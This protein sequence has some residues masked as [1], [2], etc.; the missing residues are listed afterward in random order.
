MY[1]KDYLGKKQVASATP[2]AAMETA[3][4]NFTIK[5]EGRFLQ[6][7]FML[8]LTLAI[9]MGS[10]PGLAQTVT[11]TLG[12]I[13]QDNDGLIEIC[14]LDGL[15]AIRYQLDGSGY[16]PSSSTLKITAGC[17]AIGCKGYELTRDLD[18]NDN[19][20]Y[21]STAN[22]ITWTTGKGW[23]PIGTEASPF[24]AIFNANKHRI[25]N[26]MIDRPSARNVALF[27]GIGS[28]A[29]IGGIGLINV[30]VRGSWGI[31]SLAGASRGVISSSYATGTIRG[32][33]SAGGLVG[34]NHGRITNSYTNVS[35]SGDSFIGG[36]VGCNYRS[37]TVT[38]SYTVPRINSSK[39]SRG[40]ILGNESGSVANS[41]WDMDV[42]DISNGAFGLGQTSTQLQSPTVATGI[43]SSWNA[44]VWDFGTPEQYPALKYSDGTV[45][46]DQP[47]E[48][49]EIPQIASPTSCGTTDIDQDDDGLIEICNLD[50]LRAIRYQLDG[51]GY[52]ASV[53]AAKITE[54]CPT[55]GCKGY[56]LS[57]DL[58][59]N[60]DDSYSSTANKITWTT[61]AG[62]EPI[63]YLSL[64]QH[65]PF[66]AT[67]DGN[68]HIISN[69]MIN[70]SGP[71]ALGLFSYV[72]RQS[73]IANVGLLNVNVILGNTAGGNN[74][75]GGLAGYN[76]R[77]SITN[78][79]VTGS[80]SGTG[81]Q[82]DVGGLI[83]FLEVG[84][85][86]NS[87]V[88][89]TISGGGFHTDV[90]GLVGQNLYGGRITNSYAAGSVSGTGYRT[91]VG[92]LVGWNLSRGTITN[93]YAA[94]AISGPGFIGGLIGS[95]VSGG[96][97]NSYWDKQISG[98]T[99]V[100][101]GIGKTTLELQE[102]TAATGIYSGWSTD[103]W[104]FGTSEQ[105]PALK[106]RDGT[107]M[108]NQGREPSENMLQMPQIEIA[109]VPTGA[110]D[111]GNSITL[112]ASSASSANAIPLLYS[113]SEIPS[114]GGD[115]LIQF[116]TQSSMTIEVPEDYVPASVNTV[117]LTIM[118]LAM[119]DVGSTSTV[120][121]T[122]KRVSITIAKRNNGKIAALG[123]PS[124]NERELTAPP[125]DLSG[126]PDG[127]VSNIGYQWQS[128]EDAQSAWVNVPVGTSVAYTIPENVFGTVQYRV[129]VSYTDGQGYSE[130]VISPAVVYESRYSLIEIMN[131]TS[132]GTTDVD[133]DDDGL[134]EICNLDGLNA[135]RYQL[136]GS[137]YRPSSSTLNITAGCPA[138]GCKGYELSADLD[139]GDDNSYSSTTNKITWTT[140]K[141]WQPIGAE[142]SPFNAIF[143]ANGHSISN[144][145]IDR[146]SARNVGLFGGIGGSAIVEGIALINVNVRGSWGIAS[147]AGVNRGVISSSYATGTIRGG[148]SAGGLVGDNHGQITNSYTNV[149]VSGGSWI[150]GI[151]GCNFSGGVVTNSYTVSRI[152][153]SSGSR[154]GILGNN[155]GSVANSYWDRDVNGIF[156]EGFGIGLTT[157]QLQSPI[158][159][160]STP[161]DTYYD[162]SA[163][164]WD[165]GTAE[166]YPA[167]KYRDGTVIPNQPRERPEL[168][169]SEAEIAR[170]TSCGT[171]DI[172]QDDDGLIEICNLEGLNAIRYQLDGTGYRADQSALMITMGCRLDGGCTGYELTRD[173]D[174]NDDNSYSS[175]ANK[176][177]WATGKGWE[178][179]GEM[180][181]GG[182]FMAKFEGNG[183]TIS[184]LMIN[185][186]E[187][188]YAGLFGYAKEQSEIVNIGLLNINVLGSYGAGGLA[189]VNKG[190]IT[191]SYVSGSVTGTTY[192][193]VGGLVA[194]NYGGTITSS[195]AMGSVSGTGW[196]TDVGGLVGKNYGGSITNSY[197][198][199][200]VLGTGWTTDVGG[201][202]GKN[203]GGS[204]TNSYAMGSVSGNGLFADIGGLIGENHVGSITNS[205]ATG[206]VAGSG[207]SV[208]TGGLVGQNNGTFTNSYWDKT[209]SGRVESAAGEGKTTVELQSPTAPGSTSTK[210]YY[211][212][213]AK[214]W[215]FGT[216]EQY[217]ILKHRDGT[218]M[219]NQP[220]TWSG[221]GVAGVPTDAINE[222]E[223]IT[224][225]AFPLSDEGDISLSYH[226]EQ[227]S[228]KAL[229][230]EPTTQSS[231]TLEV[232]ENY[233]SAS[234]NTA[235]LTIALMVDSDLGTTARQVVI[236]IAKQ[237]NGRIEALGAPS[238]NE[239]ELSA[240][241]IDLSGDPDGGV[242][243]ISYQWQ[244]MQSVQSTQT[245]WMNVPAGTN[246][247]YT[248]A[249]DYRGSIE[250]RV[251]VNYTDGQGYSEVARSDAVVYE[252]EYSMTEIANIISCRA[253]DIDQDDDGLIEIC[254]LE[255]LNAMRYQW[256]GSGYREDE[257][258]AK[259]TAGCGEGGCRGYE[260]VKDL[261]F[262]NS[263]HYRDL[264]NKTAWTT[265]AGW[266]PM[267]LESVFEGND[268]TIANLM[269]D[270]EQAGHVGLFGVASGG[271][272]SINGVGL[273]DVDIKAR[274]SAGG[275]VGAIRNGVSISNSY[276]T[277]DVVAQAKAGGLVGDCS[278]SAISDSHAS[279]TVSIGY[280]SAGGL[281][282]YLLVCDVS[283]SHA[284]SVVKGFDRVGGLVG[285]NNGYSNGIS[286]SYAIADVAGRGYYV[287]GL[288]G[289][290]SGSGSIIGSYAMGEVLGADT[291]GGLVGYNAARYTIRDSYSF[292]AVKGRNHVG[293]LV[294]NHIGGIINSYSV[295]SVIATG[296]RARSGG[297]VGL[298]QNS[299]MDSYW[300]KTTSGKAQSA[301]SGEGKTTAQLQS[302]T[303]TTTEIYSSWDGGIWDFGTSEQYPALKRSDG[304]LLPGQRVGLLSL[305]VF[306]SDEIPY[307][308][309]S[310]VFDYRLL[311]ANEVDTIKLLPTATSGSAVEIS[312]VSD[313]GFSESVSSGSLS[314]EISLATTQTTLITVKVDFAS[315]AS[316]TYRLT[317]SRA[318]QS[319]LAQVVGVN[320]PF[321]Y[322]F[323]RSALNDMQ[324]YEVLNMPEW[325]EYEESESGLM[326]SGTPGSD[327]KEGSLEQMLELQ[328]NNDDGTTETMSIV[329]QIDSPTT[330]TVELME[331]PGGVLQ[332]NDE[333]SDDNGIIEK[334]HIWEH[335]PVGSDEFNELEGVDGMSY[336]LP[337]GEYSVPGTAYR[338][339]TTV[340]DSLGQR[341][342]LTT[343][344]E[345]KPVIKLRIKVFL[346]GFL[347]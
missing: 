141:G 99:T 228:G 106:Y 309:N 78:S 226:W 221:V 264:D 111:E 12:D 117:D 70:R 235:Y 171:T 271:D 216:S 212:W 108:P 122:V 278:Y 236:T 62:W 38:N 280:N 209:T 109:G 263:D 89:G 217:P 24:T 130:E 148:D 203:Y 303:T 113:W 59:F 64:Y 21:S 242:G 250:Y 240:P 79:Y 199:G 188:S 308:F 19:D 317:I 299:I 340:V 145:M 289:I 293:G 298:S 333:L 311:I 331:L 281:A 338:V 13:D 16:R 169:I 243:D 304:T 191:N 237:N 51:T 8:V 208:N 258:S 165:F 11:C 52:K 150:G 25:S 183:Y 135:M 162:W 163:D 325:L 277:G 102:P 114:E 15:D 168:Q 91:D 3:I 267:R 76:Y 262:N 54:G 164:V 178:P 224:L 313:N 312:I 137:G 128:R 103:V 115:L 307:M 187:P 158:A 34:D 139:F 96:I 143:K 192:A 269:I 87:F 282:G 153:S 10:Q 2:S 66:V 222:G 26:L 194:I 318:E 292:A 234:I 160:G 6:A 273:I 146:P 339:R 104:D 324:S 297:L 182:R 134:I 46:P 131:L 288:I 296:F 44:G 200:S 283:D 261:D 345:L 112:T 204:V 4:P 149:S 159:A 85:I 230:L 245:G 290:N 53:S 266:E 227:K 247:R 205:Y 341:S 7:L 206:S 248:I 254:D 120:S 152:N 35:V 32:G 56:E 30:N 94:G 105:Y 81:Y 300:D 80:V 241:P 125:I 155:S 327:H 255:G 97:T 315:Q 123:T 347:Q 71:Y 181:G 336:T 18:F 342:E 322:V 49:P 118:L 65:D 326:F 213:D 332:L 151:V 219:P 133:Q 22:K 295:G 337:G 202:V 346:E 286:N 138:T 180:G 161:T 179:I 274:I 246:E 27:G 252:K 321:A 201:L 343:Q 268:H 305:S 170:L 5:S 93:S 334:A 198:M 132:C 110:V 320:E 335:C 249:A 173:L 172:D 157:E 284:L 265:G 177:T 223:S 63:G 92:G 184:N 36:I 147:L 33:D 330:G 323:S 39:G 211:G 95:G 116:T 107:M 124:L 302:P 239:R 190:S 260:L 58:D 45:I 210:I 231:I 175:T 186:P 23:Q 156:A 193:R 57:R 314:S 86:T 82:V 60:D 69:L 279:G 215:H 218:I 83:G 140:G 17:P 272:A 275:L 127:G 9:A 74:Y 310:E 72:G 50:G 43:Y 55:T 28:S 285:D 31:A 189:S 42:S 100:G 48:R 142:A 1:C 276:A 136:D 214:V 294:G 29:S 154:G 319:A 73:K 233:V 244:S 41:Y 257:M 251:V 166:Q 207:R 167:L 75:V 47:R 196:T 344:I 129:I 220:R 238:L 84:T 88:E 61:G 67:F 126:D 176:I 90:G 259:I 68:S 316:R 328:I 174:F 253:T 40:G 144:L 195:Y 77:A 37:G 229:L 20:S 197:A 306:A 287:G 225:M 121:S 301:G 185:R 291:V 101:G 119:S 256:D 98:R 14:D 232:P 270:R 329:L